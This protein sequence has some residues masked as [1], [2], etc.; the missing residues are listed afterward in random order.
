VAYS[1]AL[2]QLFTPS[3][4]YGLKLIFMLLVRCSA[5]P[6]TPTNNAS[7]SNPHCES[8]G[9]GGPCTTAGIRVDVSVT[10]NMYGDAAEIRL[11]VGIRKR[12]HD[13]AH[14]IADDAGL[15]AAELVEVEHAVAVRWQAAGG[16]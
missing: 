6:S 12:A 5:K 15:R 9:I 4:N 7:T 11:R 8:V 3:E 1:Y 16:E 14:D 13:A 10:L 2:I